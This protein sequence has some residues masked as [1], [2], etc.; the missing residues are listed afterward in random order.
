MSMEREEA[1][2]KPEEKWSRCSQILAFLLRGFNPAHL[3]GKTE[4][5]RD[6]H[7]L[8]NY[9]WRSSRGGGQTG[10]DIGHRSPE[11]H[12]APVLN[13]VKDQ[14][15]TLLRWWDNEE[16]RAS[17]V[18]SSSQPHSTQ[19]CARTVCPCLPVDWKIWNVWSVKKSTLWEAAIIVC[20]DF[21]C[22]APRITE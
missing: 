19:H 13:G 15:K 9:N 6:R 1:L 16:V 8:Q 22:T 18:S 21:C 20:W 4:L 2:V 17:T 3:H 12:S 5:W 7:P 14:T 11:E 10:P